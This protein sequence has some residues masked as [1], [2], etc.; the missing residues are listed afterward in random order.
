M[1][2][3]N[4][5]SN[6]PVTE[7]EVA[8]DDFFEE[9]DNEVINEQGNQ[10]SEDS[11]KAKESSTPNETEEESKETDDKEIDFAPF[12]DYLSKNAKYNKESVKV[13]NMEDVINNFQKGLNYDKLQDKLNAIQNSKAETYISRKAKELGMT[14]DEYMDQVEAYEKQQEEDKKEARFQEMIDN[15]I[16]EDIAKEVIATSELR[17]E[18][19][20][21]K[22]EQKA[23]EAEAEEKANKNKEYEDFLKAYPNVN[24][25]EIPKE[26]FEKAQDSSLKEAYTEWRLAQLEKQLSI[27]NTN[28]KNKQSSMGSITETGTTNESENGKDL[29]LE[30]FES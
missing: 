14:V 3:E 7:T 30:G 29:F 13:D 12:L 4:V 23:K 5:E 18:L 17:K 20:T 2:N 11:E 15:G 27:K 16:P 1:E 26:V 10:T 8:N 28:E 19:E 6:T 9:I 25:D 21:M 22:A 24:V